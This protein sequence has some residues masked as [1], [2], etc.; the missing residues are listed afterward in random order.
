MLTTWLRLT[1]RRPTR[2]RPVR[3]G[4]AALDFDRNLL[5][6]VG[7]D[8]RLE[9]KQAQVLIKLLAEAPGLVSKD[10]LLTYAW[11]G[12]P[13]GDDVLA[14][15]VS[16]LRKALRDDARN[17]SY[18]KTVAGRGYQLIA[19]LR[20]RDGALARMLVN[21]EQP[22]HPPIAGRTVYFGGAA[23]FLA[24]ALTLW[25]AVRGDQAPDASA[26][27]ASENPDDWQTALASYEAVY[28]RDPESVD[29][30][31]GMVDAQWRI[32]GAR[33]LLLYAAR[34]ELEG[35]LKRALAIDDTRASIHA[36]LARLAFLVD[37]NLPRAR[38]HYRRALEQA[39]DSAELHLALAQLELA[40][41]E[42][43][44]ASASLE[45]S[46]ALDP[47]IFALEMAA[48][49]YNM[50]RRYDRARL[51]LDRLV[52][53]RPD[54]L[55][56]HISAQSV[57]ENS[58]DHPRSFQHLKRV[59]E[60][61]D[62]D[63]AAL[64]EADRAFESGGLAAVYRWLRVE[65]GELRNI[66]QYQPPLA[67]AR[68]AIVSGEYDEALSLLEAAVAARQYELLW[69]RVDPKYDPIRDHPRF[70]AVVDAVVAAR[71]PSGAENTDP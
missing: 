61:V 3:F 66:G 38:R 52:A 22:T 68:Y 39:P 53:L 67:N 60:L 24:V 69:I 59:L 37:W 50:Q 6:V 32:L 4:A 54:T 15:A 55:G 40:E 17:P 26:L 18:I 46:R 10:D 57:F 23:V 29:A 8:V 7:S 56:Y 1:D 16:N 31:L 58:G 64:A 42:F 33:P 70:E 2:A 30:I 25:L 12:A 5:R 43:E 27:L 36:R 34:G 11:G 63:A 14:V 44:A 49:I 13:T 28:E 48:W 9:L 35:W 65:R 71:A 51:E 41:G 20:G 47:R 21:G 62:Y 19:P 45:R